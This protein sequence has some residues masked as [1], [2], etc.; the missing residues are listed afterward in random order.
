MTSCLVKVGASCVQRLTSSKYAAWDF[1]QQRGCCCTAVAVA[2]LH[3]GSESLGPGPASEPG[4]GP[5]SE[6]ATSLACFSGTQNRTGTFG[7]LQNH[8]WKLNIG[9]VSSFVHF[10]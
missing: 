7:S 5:G 3:S 9:Q 4:P 2:K 10:Q 6:A 8:H 1:P